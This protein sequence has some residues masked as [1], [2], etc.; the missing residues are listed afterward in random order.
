[1][2]ANQFRLWPHQREAVDAVQAEIAGGGRTRITAACGTGKTRI[3]AE[4]AALLT[5]AGRVLV[6][7]PTIE[8]IGQSLADYLARFADASP[9]VV[10]MCCDDSVAA[11]EDLAA[12]LAGLAA[13]IVVTTDAQVLAKVAMDGPPVLVFSTYAS[14]AAIAEAH[15]RRQL[16]E[17]DVVVIDEAHN[18][19]GRARG[20]WQI[21]HYD[22]RIPAQRR[23]YMTATPK[24][25]KR[26]GATIVSMDDIDIY[27]SESYRMSFAR[28]IDLGLLADYRIAVAVVTDE[29]IH[30]LTQDPRAAVRY[31]GRIV[32][33]A[34]LA[35]QIAVLRAMAEYG[36]T[37]AITYHSRIA[38]ARM[39]A[40]TL[41]AAT[42]LLPG[43]RPKVW[44]RHVDGQQ[45]AATRRQ[46]IGRLGTPG[47]G[48]VLVA[49]AKVLNEGVDAPD[50]DLVAVLGLRGET[51]T[52]QAA[53]RA[54]RTGGTPGKIATLLVPLIL[55]KGQ[56]VE[57]ALASEAGRRTW[58][59]LNAMKAHDERLDLELRMRR[60][61]MGRA[62]GSPTGP[63]GLPSWLTLTGVEVDSA[64]ADAIT[65]QAV[66]E[67][68]DDWE[69]FYGAAEA[70]KRD[71]GHIKIPEDHV[72][73]DGL[74][75]GRWW[76]KQILFMRRTRNHPRRTTL[77]NE[78]YTAL[79]ALGVEIRNNN[80]KW[81]EK[82]RQYKTLYDAA[83]GGPVRLSAQNPLTR[84]RTSTQIGLRNGAF[85][86]KRV[87]MLAAVGIRHQPSPADRWK[88]VFGQ[89]KEFYDRYGHLDIPD[90]IPVPGGKGTLRSWLDEQVVRYYGN[91]QYSAWKVT[92][93]ES[94]GLAPATIRRDLWEVGF[95]EFRRFYETHG[96]TIVPF[97]KGSRLHRWRLQRRQE[98]AAGTLPQHLKNRLDAVDPFWADP[99]NSP[100]TASSRDRFHLTDDSWNDLAGL[101]HF[102]GTWTPQLRRDAVEC[103]LW[104]IHVD[105]T[106]D[107]IKLP[108][109][110]TTT[111][112]N[113][114]L[115]LWEK[116]EQ[117]A[118]FQ[119]P[120]A[121]PRGLN[122]PRTDTEPLRLFQPPDPLDRPQT[123]IRALHHE[124]GAGDGRSPS[125]MHGQHIAAT[126]LTTGHPDPRSPRSGRTRP[127][128]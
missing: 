90:G 98:L 29:Q 121:Q 4:V 14:L 20:P 5:T 102:P 87:A 63:A 36:A 99:M 19:A 52:V 55:A 91:S 56:S 17:W 81:T 95:H 75:L 28:A 106:W 48:W 65:V 9:T 58:S 42:T 112:A 27:G 105:A 82:H 2:Q 125:A 120:P 41:D 64:F 1:M 115:G 24:I 69:Q 97:R 128:A 51:D 60:R 124:D 31:D 96:H 11:R 123:P 15:G 59:V 33:T 13:E 61:A 83:A 78:R 67:C 50:V 43:D 72:T 127:H 25:S 57:D 44:S 116:A 66:L 23:F 38:E 89:V 122:R 12:D 92:L 88:A 71:N 3:G 109:V 118:V 32:P 94:L 74:E 62:P 37:R 117:L 84:W 30:Q 114:A 18:T 68:T 80:E 101:L 6:A 16:L 104:K 108:G 86:S 110:N 34:M 10:A 76:A 85:D 22:D 40:R 79:T 35:M 126:V 8:L 53:G 111:L 26:R 100:G 119:Q 46:V 45:R 113:W 93:M 73:T 103:V 49:N 39:W 107:D 21:V 47:D 7:V 54:L 77:S 70:F